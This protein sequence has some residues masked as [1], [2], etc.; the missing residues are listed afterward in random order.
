MYTYNFFDDIMNLRDFFDDFFSRRT[1]YE[2]YREFPYVRIEEEGDKLIITSLVPGIMP[3]DLD[4]QVID[5]SLLISGEKKADYEEKAYL[6]KE[7]F[8]GEFKK[9][10]KLPFRINH[11]NIKADLKDG[12]LTIHLEKSEDSKPKKIEIK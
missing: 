1:S 10:I 2:P 8:F 12:I 9:S 5:D 6:R 11:D 3:E 7:R 4:I